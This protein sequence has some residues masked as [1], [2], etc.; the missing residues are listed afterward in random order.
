MDSHVG[1]QWDPS[2]LGPLD[3]EFTP[4]TGAVR[5]FPGEE[6]YLS[7]R[8]LDARE[9]LWR[10]VHPHLQ[11]VLEADETVL[12]VAPVIHNPRFLEVFGFG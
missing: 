10:V 2:F 11:R 9:K 1:S 12:H 8:K 5:L 4:V 3:A 7:K 6:L